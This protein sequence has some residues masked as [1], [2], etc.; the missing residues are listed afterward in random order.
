ME[1]VLDQ[2]SWQRNVWE[3][4][5][6]S[7]EFIKKYSHGKKLNWANLANNINI[8]P[9]FIED[10][11][12]NLEMFPGLG[13]LQQK[14]AI[15]PQNFMKII[16]MIIIGISIL[17][18]QYSMQNLL[19]K[20][21]PDNRKGSKVTTRCLVYW[22]NKSVTLDLLI[23]CGFL[24]QII[25][26]PYIFNFIG[27]RVTYEEAEAHPEIDWNYSVFKE[28]CKIPLGRFSEEDLTFISRTL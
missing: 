25:S 27:L 16:L 26:S 7:L 5:N 8:T 18:I 24:Q 13:Y 2:Y 17:R 12:S 14:S 15:L 3:N 20:H 21:A 6:L 23:K 11:V 19:K 28:N 4:H 22:R 10:N 1:Y 9:E